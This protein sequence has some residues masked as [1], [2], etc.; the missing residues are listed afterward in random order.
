MKFLL[1]VLIL[2]AIACCTFARPG[3]HGW[4]PQPV[5]QAPPQEIHVYR[6]TVQAPS[7][8]HGPPVSVPVKAV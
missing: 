8:A 6:E 7:H 3:G 5:H 4:A 2:A 1:V